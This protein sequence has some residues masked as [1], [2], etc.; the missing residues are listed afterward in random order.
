LSI[1]DFFYLTKPI[2]PRSLQINLRRVYAR[3]KLRTCRNV[4]PIDHGAG[5]PPVGWA[6]WPAKKKFALVL[7]HDVDT[8]AGH[9]RCLQVA[10]TEEELGFRSC[11]NFVPEG[12]PVSPDLRREL[13]ERGFDVGVHGLVHDSKLFKSRRIF[14]ERSS[15]INH[16]LKEWGAAGFHSPATI[17]NLSWIGELDI[18]YDGSTFDS[19][20]FE[21][22][23]DGVRTIFPFWVAGNSREEGYVEL[24]YTL[25]QDH[26]LF[27]ILQEKDISVWKRKLDWVAAKGGMTLLNSHPDYMNFEKR[28]CRLEEYPAGHYVAFLEYIKSKYEGLYWHV[29]PREMGRFWRRVIARQ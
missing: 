28:R 18:E 17:R 22:H 9:D 21:P 5:Q 12:Y 23:P 11:F 6:G 15:R 29:L 13:S 25:P 19:D 26:C 20:P 27:I 7:S 1:L 10:E 24:P 3:S 2:I 16:Y 14:E 4:W 8:A